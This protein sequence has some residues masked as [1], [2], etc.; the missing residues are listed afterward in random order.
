M[1]PNNALILFEARATGESPF[2]IAADIEFRQL[3]DFL[4]ADFQLLDLLFW[5]LAI[6]AASYFAK[7]PL[8]RKEG[9]AIYTYRNRPTQ[10]GIVT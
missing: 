6:Y 3:A 10:S 2:D 5:P 8:S 9:L 1:T 7:R 4:V